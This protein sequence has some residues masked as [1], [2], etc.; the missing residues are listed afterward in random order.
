MMNFKKIYYVKKNKL[1]KWLAM[2]FSGNIAGTPMQLMLKTLT[3]NQMLPKRLVAL[4][5]FGFIGTSVTMD[6]EYLADYIEMWEI[7]PYYAKQAAKNIPKAKVVCGD[8]IKSIKDG[9]LFR[10]DYNFIVIDPNVFMSN[11]DSYESIAVFNHALKYMAEEAVIFVGFVYN[12]S[13]YIE[14]Y[15]GIED[16]L[17][18]WLKA[19]KDFFEIENV[20]NGRGIDYLRGFEGI[21][22][23]NNIN[24]VFSQFISRNDYAGFGV[25]VLKK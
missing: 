9:G 25:F 24:L 19:R 20:I 5:L 3:A 15:G 17:N 16:Q 8:S 12:A 21:I 4:E 2:K 6:Y 13:K 14:K 1:S 23:T 22:K 7:D 10:N 11:Y 18:K